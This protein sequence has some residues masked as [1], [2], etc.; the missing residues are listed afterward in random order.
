[1]G[2]FF[3]DV[4]AIPQHV[5]RTRQPPFPIVG[6]FR[7]DRHC[8]RQKFIFWYSRLDRTWQWITCKRALENFPLKGKSNGLLGSFLGRD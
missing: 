7:F 1:M 5:L 4:S 2:L 3:L 8:C 6:L